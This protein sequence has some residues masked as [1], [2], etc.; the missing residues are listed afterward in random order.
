MT[1]PWLLV[2]L[3]LLIVFTSQF[4]WK[5]QFGNEVEQGSN[6]SQK[7]QRVSKREEAVK[8]K[9]YPFSYA[10]SFSTCWLLAVLTSILMLGHCEW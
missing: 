2:F 7:E 1:R 5:Q 8:E 3:L 4:E 9:V 10:I 6:A